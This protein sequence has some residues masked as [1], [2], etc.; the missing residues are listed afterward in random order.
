MMANYRKHGFGGI[1]LEGVVMFFNKLKEAGKAFMQV[2]K[3]IR[4]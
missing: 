2:W 3:Y 1:V 4:G